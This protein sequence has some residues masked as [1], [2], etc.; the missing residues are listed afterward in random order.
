MYNKL[1]IQFFILVN[2]FFACGFM[3]I[4]QT[5][6]Y[7]KHDIIIPYSQ[8]NGNT[9][10]NRK[11]R[12]IYSK[13]LL[14][15]RKTRRILLNNTNINTL[16]QIINFTNDFVSNYTQQEKIELNTSIIHN[17][18][19]IT[20]KMSSTHI[21]NTDMVVKNI[22]MG[23]IVL[24]VS[25]VKHIHISTQNDEILIELDKQERMIDLQNV[26]ENINNLDAIV[27]T[28]TMIGKLMNLN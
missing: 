1:L 21:N 3:N 25:N 17:T 8:S 23:N 22:M 5:P 15:L 19:P 26:L 14:G 9:R 2:L 24:D 18:N 6:L 28:I 4:F 16:S 20:P 7:N 11:E 12:N 27:T 13:Y 10:G